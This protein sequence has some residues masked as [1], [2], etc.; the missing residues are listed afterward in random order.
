MLHVQREPAEP[1][2]E[3]EPGEP[4]LVD[5]DR[6]QAGE[7]DLQRMVVEQRDPEQR[8]REQD[9]VD[10]NAEQIERFGRGGRR[11]REGRRASGQRRWRT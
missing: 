9:E 3:L 2:A 7:R 10:R 4:E 8:Q 11:S 6:R 1:A 5:D